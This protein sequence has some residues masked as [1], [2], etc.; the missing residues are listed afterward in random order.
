[1]K[2]HQSFMA[3]LAVV[4]MLGQPGAAILG[5]GALINGTASLIGGATNLA[6]NLA[7][8]VV[9]AGANVVSGAV[10]GIT[11]T[12]QNVQNAIT[13]AQV[14]GQF[15]WDNAIQPTLTVLQ[16]SNLDFNHFNK[17]KRD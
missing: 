13:V 7:G 12:V 17:L 11:N 6:A 2:P 16:D 14:G 10:N 1:M 9:N 3:V 15:L 5:L 8:S 4:A